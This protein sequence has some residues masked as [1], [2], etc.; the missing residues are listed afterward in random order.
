MPPKLTLHSMQHYAKKGP[1][2]LQKPKVIESLLAKGK[3]TDITADAIIGN[4]LFKDVDAR[5][6]QAGGSSFDEV[7]FTNAIFAGTK[8]DKASFTDVIT[9]HCDFS[10][11]ICTDGSWTRVVN[12]AG[13]MTGIDVSKCT[14]KDVVFRGCK[15]DM[16][17]FRFAKLTRV[18]FVDCVLGEADF[19]GAEL[20][21]VGFQS[22]VLEKV[23]FSQAKLKQV[24]ARSSHIVDIRGWQSL[25]GL[26][27]DQVQLM[28]VAPQMAQALEIEIKE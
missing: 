24:D 6:A 16:A 19:L 4:V 27:I 28:E 5:E 15:L 12:A 22:C 9:D 14:M 7:V 18:Q 2:I 8:L 1:M 3:P 25:K 20:S 26:I 11:T 23:E 17:N 21:Q 10:S 13:R